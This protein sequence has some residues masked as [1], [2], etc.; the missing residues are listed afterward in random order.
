[1]D[2]LFSLLSIC[3]DAAPDAA[4][5]AAATAP[6]M[7]HTDFG[8]VPILFADCIPALLGFPF[9][10]AGSFNFPIFT[11]PCKSIVSVPIAISFFFLCQYTQFQVIK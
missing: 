6:A 3:L 7:N 5:A 11:F 9:V 4:A 2:S 8:K 1:M 10:A